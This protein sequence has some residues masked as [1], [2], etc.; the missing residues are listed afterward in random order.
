M[1]HP[2]KSKTQKKQEARIVEKLAQELLTLPPSLI[3]EA[4]CDTNILNEIKTARDMKQFGARRRQTKYLAKLL[5]GTDPEPLLDFMEKVKKSRLKQNKIF[6]KLE[7]LRDRIIHEEEEE[8]ALQEAKKNFP[9][10]NDELVKEYARK[11]RLTRNEKFSREIFRQ[12]KIA[13]NLNA[14]SNA[15]YPPAPEDNNSTQ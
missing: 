7:R 10:L 13:Q 2:Y 5:R 14:Q 11:Y 1:S 3:D 8:E 4:P 6:H 12:L 15:L 9:S